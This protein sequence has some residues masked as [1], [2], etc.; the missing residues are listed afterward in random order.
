MAPT[1]PVP[2]AAHTK[3]AKVED[4]QPL[5]AQGMVPEQKKARAE[6]EEMNLRGG[7][8]GEMCPG[9]FCFIIPCPLPCNFCII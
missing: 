6:E 5:P 1:L 2:A 7:G 4:V 9:R 8:D 3:E